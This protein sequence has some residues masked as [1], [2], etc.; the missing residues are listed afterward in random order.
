[1]LLVKCDCLGKYNI[2]KTDSCCESLT[3]CLYHGG[4]DSGLLFLIAQERS[5]PGS[6]VTLPHLTGHQ[7]VLPCSTFRKATFVADYSLS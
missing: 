6:S 2:E 3:L 7:A 5:K 4:T 1:M